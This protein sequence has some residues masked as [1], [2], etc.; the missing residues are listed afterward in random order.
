MVMIFVRQA[1][2]TAV[3]LG[4]AAG[5]VGAG[6]LLSTSPPMVLA[7]A[8]A[9][10]ASLF[11]YPGDF[12]HPRPLYLTN[13]TLR[14][15]NKPSFCWTEAAAAA[16]VSVAAAVATV[17]VGVVLHPSLPVGDRLLLAKLVAPASVP[18]AELP[19][20]NRSSANDLKRGGMEVVVSFGVSPVWPFSLLQ[21]Q[22]V[23]RM[24]PEATDDYWGEA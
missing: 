12:P 14:V 18:P 23:L 3:V 4:G 1:A 7:S 16:G 24:E 11:L 21:R 19:H 8:R 17:P 13:V 5:A 9:T 20:W 6:V 10:G 2:T 22:V 15:G